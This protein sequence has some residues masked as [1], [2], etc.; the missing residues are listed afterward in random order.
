MNLFENIKKQDIENIELVFENTASIKINPH[1][2]R[3]FNYFGG[4]LT[5]VKKNN[6]YRNPVN[7]F[8][9][10]STIEVEKVQFKLAKKANTRYCNFDVVG[11]NQR[12]FDRLNV[13]DI[14]FINITYITKTNTRKILKLQVPYSNGKNC[15]DTN[16][17]QT[18]KFTN[19]GLIVE[20]IDTCES[21]GCA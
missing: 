12:L 4:S 1:L 6:D 3:C 8:V 10:E 7:F 11:K 15:F 14:T 19:D 18:N 13:K 17:Y 20:I 9:E 5:E 21:K 2:F 16:N